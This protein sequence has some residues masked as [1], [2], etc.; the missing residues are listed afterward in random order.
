MRDGRLHIRVKQNLAEEIRAY[1]KRKQVTV[2]FLI[3]KHLWELLDAEQRQK[4][5]EQL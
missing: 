3:E 2:S 4:D 1:A 5:A